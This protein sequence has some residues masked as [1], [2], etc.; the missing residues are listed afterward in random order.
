MRAWQQAH[1]FL[2]PTHLCTRRLTHKA[3]AV[4]SPML[5][6]APDPRPGSCTAPHS[7]WPVTCCRP[8]SHLRGPQHPGSVTPSSSCTQALEAVSQGCDQDAM[9]FTGGG[10]TPDAPASCSSPLLVLL[11]LRPQRPTSQLTWSS[12]SSPLTWRTGGHSCPCAPG[13]SSA[14]RHRVRRLPHCVPAACLSPR[15]TL[16]P[17]PAQQLKHVSLQPSLLLGGQSLSLATAR[18][19][20]LHCPV[21]A[22]W[23]LGM[24]WYLRGTPEPH[25]HRPCPQDVPLPSQCH[26]TAQQHRQAAWPTLW[27]LGRPLW[28][29]TPSRDSRVCLSH[30]GQEVSRS[31][32]CSCRT[33][34]ACRCTQEAPGIPPKPC[35]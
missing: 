9:L 4:F 7:A 20:P 13:A 8:K 14:S 19:L 1:P 28:L 30:S 24:M 2:L 26:C 34:T 15:C 22:C 3:S 25:S 17:R 23:Q 27:T 29:Q 21:R 12:P 6:G 10:H 11:T 32:G 5:L 33:P 18:L 31:A 35:S 16:L